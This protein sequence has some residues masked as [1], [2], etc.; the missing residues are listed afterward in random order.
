MLIK[1]FAEKMSIKLTT[2]NIKNSQ[3]E[4]LETTLTIPLN[5][6]V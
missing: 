2:S 6:T 5:K 4:G 1:F 3:G